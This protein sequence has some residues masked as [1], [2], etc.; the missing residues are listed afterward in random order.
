MTAYANINFSKDFEEDL[1]LPLKASPPTKAVVNVSS[2]K[3][4]S[5]FRYPGGK[6]WLVPQIRL[7][8]ASL[9]SP[10]EHLIEP[11][12]G[13]GI[14]GL[15]ALFDG[16]AEK[17]T[18][19]EKDHNVGAVW[20]T[21]VHGGAPELADRICKFNLTDS[22]INDLFN[23]EIRADDLLGKA[24]T[25][26]VRNRV[27]RGGIMAPG[28]SI[29]RNG[30]SGRGVASR[31]YPETL[32]K[33]L[34]DLHTI[35]GRIKFHSGDGI[36]FVKKHAANQDLTWF[37]DPPY[38]VAGRRLYLHSELDH[39]ELFEQAASLAGSFLMTYDETEAIRRLAEKY[40]LKTAEISMKNTH[41]VVKNELLISR[42]LD[43]FRD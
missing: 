40:Q 3:H 24:F 6:T 34:L 9:R 2:V 12:A 36:A 29:M 41:H 21:I 4:R 28:A 11:F 22:A 23:A 1:L 8:L 13:G 39:D 18:F 31:W 14:V 15:S 27:Q 26:I 33:R 10:V 17:L 42:D 7:W 43:W 19:V 25:T 5:P 32:K 20:Q 38:T 30:E 16:L 35:H 37:I